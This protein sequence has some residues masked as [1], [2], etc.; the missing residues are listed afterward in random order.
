M[1][2]E[3]ADL[4]PL[5]DATCDLRARLGDAI[6][7]ISIDPDDTHADE[8]RRMLRRAVDV[9]DQVEDGVLAHLAVFDAA[10]DGAVVARFRERLDVALLGGAPLNLTRDALLD[11]FRAMVRWTHERGLH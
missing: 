1:K 10:W 3:I 7:E 5:W 9:L 8:Q 4:A 6:A 2:H 11:E